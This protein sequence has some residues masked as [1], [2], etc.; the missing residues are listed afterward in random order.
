MKN[1]VKAFWHAVLKFLGFASTPS[2]V[3]TPEVQPVP[4]PAPDPVII[5][6]EPPIVVEPMPDLPV[7]VMPEPPKEAP[8]KPDPVIETK[9]QPVPVEPPAPAKPDPVVIPT[10]PKPDTKPQPLPPAA[11]KTGRDL[12]FRFGG[13]IKEPVVKNPKCAALVNKHF[14]P[15]TL[16]YQSQMNVVHP[17]AKTWNFK[18]VDKVTK[19]CKENDHP[20]HL[21]CEFWPMKLKNNP[22]WAALPKTKEAFNKQIKSD[23]YNYIGHFAKDG[24]GESVD[25]WNEFYEEGKNGVPKSNIILDNMGMDGFY[26]P[27]YYTKEANPNIKTFFNE[28]GQEFGGNKVKGMLAMVDDCLKKGVPLDGIGF[29]MHLTLPMLKKDKLKSIR[30]NFL[31][32]ADKGMQIRVSE[33]DISLFKD[34]NGRDIRNAKK[35]VDVTADMLE[36]Q[37][38]LAY[39]VKQAYMAVPKELQY[40]FIAWGVDDETHNENLGAS[41]NNDFPLFFDNNLEPKPVFERFVS[42]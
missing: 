24:V 9:P 22:Q 30:E 6:T 8:V 38:E 37:A 21:H 2:T 31:K 23:V 33:F 19:W 1:L 35:K 39:E 40:A 42:G 11:E 10:T 7:E 15:V 29:Q 28:Y 32:F 20:V 26:R 3:E 13:A 4:E 25:V 16:E 5:P 12:P 27:F 17:D 41:V 14:G 36:Q 34:I 18:E